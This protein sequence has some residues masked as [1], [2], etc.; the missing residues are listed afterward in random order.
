M[1]NTCPRSKDV[2]PDVV[3]S[4]ATMTRDLVVRLDRAG[5]I[6]DLPADQTKNVRNDMYLVSESLRLRDKDQ[7]FHARPSRRRR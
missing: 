5:T 2:V 6:K 4:L 1:V 3:P 7:T